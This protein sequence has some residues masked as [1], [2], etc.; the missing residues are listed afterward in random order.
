[1]AVYTNVNFIEG[2]KIKKVGGQMYSLAVVNGGL[3]W[4]DMALNPITTNTPAYSFS[5]QYNHP[6]I[7]VVNKDGFSYLLWEGWNNQAYQGWGLSWGD[8]VL[9]KSVQTQ[10]GAEYNQTLYPYP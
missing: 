8:R 1:V 9:Q 3:L 10:I 7:I 6:N 2:T 4:L 5:G